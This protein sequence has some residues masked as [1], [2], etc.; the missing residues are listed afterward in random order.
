MSGR[1]DAEQGKRALTYPRQLQPV[2]K[3][4]DSKPPA[5]S[6]RAQASPLSRCS[7]PLVA[8]VLW[9]GSGVPFSP[10]SPMSNDVSPL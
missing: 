4:G 1:I 2:P 10:Y 5:A 7:V 8:A 6:P 9:A 3:A